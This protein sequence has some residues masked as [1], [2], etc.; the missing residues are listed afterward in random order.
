[1]KIEPIVCRGWKSICNFIG[2][3][4]KRTAKKELTRIGLLNYEFGRP[5]LSRE[6]YLKV[7]EERLIQLPSEYCGPEKMVED[8]II[9]SLPKHTRRKRQFKTNY[10]IIDIFIPGAPPTIIEV[11]NKPTPGNIQSAIGQLLLYRQDYPN[12][13]LYIAC[14]DKIPQKYM[15]A[16][17]PLGIKEWHS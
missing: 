1:M 13:D 2:V 4:D 6:V 15:I 8:K 10:G 16:I 12:A 5:V 11:K 14:A 7:K 17:E 3:K 9:A